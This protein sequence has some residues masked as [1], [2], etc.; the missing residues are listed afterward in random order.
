MVR[1]VFDLDRCLRGGTPSPVTLFG[2]WKVT[3]KDDRLGLPVPGPHLLN[4]ETREEGR[5]RE[6]TLSVPTQI[7]LLLRTGLSV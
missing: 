4:P 1:T 3:G 2:G 7:R 5:G 6:R